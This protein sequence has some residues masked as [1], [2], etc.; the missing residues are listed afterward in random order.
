MVREDRLEGCNCPVGPG[1]SRPWGHW[2]SCL[3]YAERP[4]EGAPS[5]LSRLVTGAL[6]ADDGWLPDGEDATSTGWRRETR[7]VVQHVEV[8]WTGQHRMHHAWFT[9]RARFDDVDALI[10]YV[11]ES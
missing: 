4:R 8:Y 7:S 10:K 6:H 9:Q 2:R 5:D 3:V 1:V 11:K